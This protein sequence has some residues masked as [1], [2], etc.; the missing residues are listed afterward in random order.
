MTKVTETIMPLRRVWKPLIEQM[1]Q[2][3][4]MLILTLSVTGAANAAT[5]VTQNET[6]NG[7]ILS[8]SEALVTI[9]KAD[10]QPVIIARKDIRQILDDNGVQ[11]WQAGQ[12]VQAAATAQ[13]PKA[14]GEPLLNFAAKSVVI[15]FFAGAAFGGFYSEENRFIDAHNIYV[16][17]SDGSRQNAKTSMFQVGLGVNFQSYSSA[18]W[19]WLFSYVFRS[20]QQNIRTGDG[21]KYES[22]TLAS[23]VATT[24]HALMFGRELHFYPG[25]GGSSI[26]LAAQLGYEFGKYAPLA[27]YNEV[28]TKLTPVPQLYDIATSV[29]VHGPT[30]RL[31]TG[32]TFRGTNWQLRLFGY[33][34]I[35]YTFAAERIWAAVEKNTLVHDIYGGVSVGYGF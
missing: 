9:R 30:A 31:G 5:I 24:F 8:Q 14:G 26:D 13:P 32:I 28:R 18:R 20:T 7:T 6:I 25:D 1:K 17:Y 4:L 19:S 27:S 2:L 33:Y 29:A 34:Q 21:S 12:P 16:L 22:K 11:V 35:A 15:D 10:G 3:T 23:S